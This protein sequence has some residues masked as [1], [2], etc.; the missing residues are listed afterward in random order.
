MATVYCLCSP[1]H[2]TAARDLKQTLEAVRWR[3]RWLRGS[4][5]E[6]ASSRREIRTLSLRR[7]GGERLLFCLHFQWSNLTFF[8]DFTTRIGNL[9]RSP[10]PSSCCMLWGH[11]R[12][13]WI[14][15]AVEFKHVEKSWLSL[16]RLRPIW[17][18]QDGRLSPWFEHRWFW[19]SDF[20]R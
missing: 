7:S 9:S 4:W 6:T 14:S 20:F 16:R 10:R 15:V 11:H 5:V 13:G 19:S 2:K 8:V 18:G 17:P 1:I 3:R 12:R